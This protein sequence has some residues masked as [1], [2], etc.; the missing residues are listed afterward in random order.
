MHFYIMEKFCDFFTLRPSN[1]NTTLTCVL[2][3]NF[4]PSFLRIQIILCIFC[5]NQFIVFTLQL[6]SHSLHLLLL[7]LKISIFLS[8]FVMS[9]A[10]PN[11]AY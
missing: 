11:L 7:K 3:D 2:M 1:L 10:V 5:L 6:R 8:N 9:K 4:C